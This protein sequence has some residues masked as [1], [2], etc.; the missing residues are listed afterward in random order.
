MKMNDW[1]DPTYIC[2]D[3]L[4]VKDNFKTAVIFYAHIILAKLQLLERQKS[5]R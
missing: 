1:I 2:I 3:C 4:R 5:F